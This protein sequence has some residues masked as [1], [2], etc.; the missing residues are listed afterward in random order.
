[1]SWLSGLGK[2][3]GKIALTAAPYV[4]APFTGGLS[5]M[6]APATQKIVQKWSES[7]A[8]K[9]LAKGLAP[10]KFDSVLGKVGQ[11]ASMASMFIPG[12]QL[13]ALGNM[14]T[15]TKMFA[16]IANQVGT[17]AIDKIGSGGASQE[18]PPQAGGLAPS[19]FNP[20]P[21]G[22]FGSNMPQRRKLGFGNA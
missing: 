4:A 3:V 5:L 7:D 9:N 22:Q 15:K 11:G 20:M 13:G 6:A 8:K 21:F 19:S 12:G 2:K 14:G 18:M 10:S 1:M 17:S 16:D